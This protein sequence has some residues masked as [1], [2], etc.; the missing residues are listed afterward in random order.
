MTTATINHPVQRATMVQPVMAFRKVA[1]AGLQLAL[2][3]AAYWMSYQM[4][5]DFAPD[6]TMLRVMLVSLPV[7]LAVKLVAFHVFGLF[8]GWWRYVGMSD[9]LDITKAAVSSAAVLYFI[10]GVSR[11]DEAVPRSVIGLDCLLTLIVVGGTRFSVRAYTEA[12]QHQSASKNT[13]V[14]GT[15]PEAANVVRELRQNPD[16]GYEP[17]GIVTNDLSLCG[18]KISGIPV[19]GSINSLDDK[20]TKYAAR[21][22][23]V[24]LP[25][26][27]NT[28][29]Q[30]IVERCRSSKVEFKILPSLDARMNGGLSVSKLR[31]LNVEDLLGR[32]PVKLDLDAIRQKLTGKV[33]LVTG[34]GGSIGSELVRQIATFGPKRLVL[35]DQSENDQFKL[36]ME[37]SRRFPNIEHV[38]VIGDILDVG[39]LREVFA[40]HHPD[41]VFHAAAYKHVPLMEHNCFQAISNN[42]FGTY[43]VALIAGQFGAKDF[44]LISTDKAVNPTNVMGATKRIAELVVLALQ[45][46]NTRFVCVRFGNVL[47]SNGSVIPIFQQQIA[48]G[49]PVTVTHPNV[50]RYFMT[51]PE[52]VQLVLQASTMGV[53][54]EIFVLDMGEPVR[55]SQLAEDLIRLSGLEPGK[56]ISVIYTGLR[57]GEKLYEELCLSAEGT[58]PTRHQ[59]IHVLDGGYVDFQHVHG[60]LDQLSGAVTAKN[61]DALIRHVKAIVPEYTPSKEVLA[62]C[63]VD[64]HDHA[65]TFGIA[66]SELSPKLQAAQAARTA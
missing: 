26:S 1:I 16:V 8:R 24:A 13:L 60:W 9:L 14:V 11:M 64:H 58:K 23:L 52:A 49:G 5:F 35:V 36:S 4:R 53:G 3:C 29:V 34:S 44:V 51:I 50:T 42:V 18:T 28:E 7:V 21:C 12:V 37:L 31:T 17:V 22:V 2:V 20:I 47:G 43:N 65:L 54:G 39:M 63:A 30:Q 57:P 19:V 32:P 56:D 27:S 59:K 10:F 61:M 6:R 40:F 33:V 45:Q 38:T 48:Q 66:R 62:L 25:S 15:G 55:I 41:S 46:H